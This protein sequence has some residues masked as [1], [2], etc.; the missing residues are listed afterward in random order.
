MPRKTPAF[1][2]PDVAVEWPSE[3]ELVASPRDRSAPRLADLADSLPFAY[4]K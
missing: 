4:E 2:L 1:R 3:H